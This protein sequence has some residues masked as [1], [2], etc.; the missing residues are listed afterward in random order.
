M[1]ER[2]LYQFLLEADN[3]SGRLRNALHIGQNVKKS[4]VVNA[5]LK[6]VLDI[7]TKIIYVLLF[8]YI[9]YRILSTISVWEGFQLRQSIV[10]FTVFFELY[11]RFSYK[12]GNV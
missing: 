9:P 10:Y 2:I 8:M 5:A 3:E 7:V 4:S 1:R 11:M 6:I 12:L